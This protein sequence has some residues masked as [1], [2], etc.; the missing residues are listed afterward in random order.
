[1]LPIATHLS[2]WEIVVE[3]FCPVLDLL[4]K[5]LHQVL[6]FCT[7]DIMAQPEPPASLV[8]PP[9]PIGEYWLPS[10][11]PPQLLE[12]MVAHENGPLTGQVHGQTRINCRFVCNPQP[13]VM[14][15]YLKQGLV[16][17][18]RP[19]EASVCPES[20]SYVSV[21]LYPFPDSYMAPSLDWCQGFGCQPET[22]RIEIQV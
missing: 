16:D 21:S 7:V 13:V 17:K 10:V 12:E 20:V 5:P 19:D 14:T 1:M 4:D 11:H 9:G 22:P 18:Y 3:T 8:V 15:I 2:T 6:Q